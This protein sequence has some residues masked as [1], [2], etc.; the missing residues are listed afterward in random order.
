M[1]HV[2]FPNGHDESWERAAPLYHGSYIRF[3]CIEFVF[4]IIGYPAPLE[5]RPYGPKREPIIKHHKSVSEPKR[6]EEYRDLSVRLKSIL[7]VLSSKPDPIPYQSSNS[8]RSSRSS[9]SSSGSLSP[10]I[11]I[12]DV[13]EPRFEIVYDDTEIVTVKEVN[14]TKMND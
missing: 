14:E 6:T 2:K 8:D 5:D 9:P 10:D 4:S 3:G 13:S 1:N 7:N 12:E 11:K